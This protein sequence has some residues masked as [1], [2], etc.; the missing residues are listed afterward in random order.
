MEVKILDEPFIFI[1]GPD[2]GHSGPAFW[3]DV[4]QS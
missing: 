4:F 1:L 3:D 2:H